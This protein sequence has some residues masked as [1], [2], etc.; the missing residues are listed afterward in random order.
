[1]FTER[2][3]RLV[4][5]P[6]ALAYALLAAVI[7]MIWLG[8]G[9]PSTPP[10]AAVPTARPVQ[11]A[12]A[13]TLRPDTAPDA[14]LLG[15][16]EAISSVRRF[17]GDP[18]LPLEAGLQSDLTGAGAMDLYYLE[19]LI[20]TRGEDFFKVDA[21]TG[22]VVEATLRSH[23]APTNPPIDLGPAES[24]QTAARFA[25]DRFYGFSALQLVDRASRT[26]ENNHIYSFKWS[27]IAADSGA[28]LPVSVSVAVSA[29]SGEVVW[30]LAQRDLLQVDPRPSIDRARA[31]RVATG[32]L[33]ASASRW[34]TGR[35]SAVRL[36]VLYDEDNEQ[37]LV[38]SITF[39]SRQEGTRPTLRVL[40]DAH[41]GQLIAGPS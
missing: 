41:S 15:P 20:P 39:R 28:E 9:R 29:G 18:S 8:V 35:P 5:A 34:D 7:A 25:A 32:G 38:W 14:P 1:V 31:I 27:E 16:E 33:G 2:F 4:S 12:S 23:L 22:E 30:Y 10:A 24:E 19:S 11:D 40:V 37:Q 6:G 21:R 17:V 36:Q 13:V 3:V 26:S